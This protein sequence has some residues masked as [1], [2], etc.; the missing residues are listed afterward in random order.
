MH[1]NIEEMFPRCYSHSSNLY[2]KTKNL[3]G[4][5]EEIV[6]PS[7]TCRKERFNSRFT[8]KISNIRMTLQAGLSD[9]NSLVM[10]L[11][12]SAFDYP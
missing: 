3:I 10:S 1:E 4:F 8:D 11:V 12:D 2:Q 7:R 5:N 9:G 6:L